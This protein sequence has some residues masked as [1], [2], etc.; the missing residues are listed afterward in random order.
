MDLLIVGAGPTGLAAG[1]EAARHGLTFRIVDRRAGPSVHSKALGVMPR[2]LEVFDDW[3]IAGRAVEQGWVGRKGN[4][5]V[6]GGRIAE[7]RLDGIESPYPN[8]LVLAQSE[9]ERLMIDRLAAG[10]VVVEREVEAADLREENGSIHATLRR[11]GGEERVQARWMIGAD[12]A[13]STARHAV[14]L[15]FEGAEYPEEFVLA[16]VAI[17]WGLAGGEFHAFFSGSDLLVAIPMGKESVYRLIATRRPGEETGEDPDL[18][19]FERIVAEVARVE[20]RLSRP[21]WMARFRLHRRMVPRFRSGCVFLAG[22]AA[23]IHSPIGAQGMNTGIQDAH[24]LVWKMALVSRGLAGSSLLDTYDAERRPIAERVLRWT[25]VAFR[26]AMGQSVPAR[27]ARRVLPALALGFEPVVARLRRAVSQIAISYDDSPIV[28]EGEGASFRGG[29]SPGARAPDVRLRETG[30]GSERRLFELLRGPRHV[31]LGFLPERLERLGGRADPLL[32]DFRG[33]LASAL[34]GAA[35][36]HW[37]L[38]PD[39]EMV[40]AGAATA[41]RVLQDPTGEAGERYGVGSEGALYLVRPDGHVAWRGPMEPDPPL[42]F[43]ERYRT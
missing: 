13:H 21:E 23:H 22:D 2:T 9:T 37:I 19:E 26:I 3:G 34:G 43:L 4:L 6:D 30:G 29:P 28:A 25:D 32:V 8:L 5:H 38:R 27:L 15:P 17:E 40:G 1:I 12:G 18:E 14:G 10:G 31:A 7:L 24:N 39:V 16:D 20:A 41:R 42:R 36:V 11:D 35:R 33:R